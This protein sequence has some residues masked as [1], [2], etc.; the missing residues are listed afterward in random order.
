MYTNDVSPVVAPFVQNFASVSSAESI[1]AAGSYVPEVNPVAALLTTFLPLVLIC[2]GCGIVSHL[3]ARKKGYSGYFW[4]GFFLWA[5]GLMYV[6]S[7][8]FSSA[9][10]LPVDEQ[11]LLD[12]YRR[13]D[14]E[15]KK[16]LHETLGS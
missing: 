6:A 7:L 3:I 2:L 14:Q 5:F 11:M 15:G 12:K 16:K 9:S 10:S 4:T 8:P 13:L 1:A